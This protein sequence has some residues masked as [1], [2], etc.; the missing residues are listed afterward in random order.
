MENFNKYLTTS[1]LEEK[2]GFYI[3]TAGFSR[4]E[5][6]QAYPDNRQHPTTHAF[7]WDNGRILNGYYLIF[8]S[9]GEGIF[10]TEAAKPFR[11]S[12]G[13]CFVLFPG[14]WHRY[15]PDLNT[16]WE[17]YWIGF[18]GFYADE[19]IRRFFDKKKPVLYTGL[20]EDMLRL[21]QSVLM[22]IKDAKP[23]YHQEIAGITHQMLGLLNAMSNLDQTN[24]SPAEQLV[25]TAKFLLRESLRE[26]DRLENIIKDL[27]VSYSKFRKD[28]KRITGQSPNQ[29]QL[30]L[31]LEKV[32][33]LLSI[34]RLSVSEIAY[35]TGFDSVSH[36]SKT[37]TKKY[38]LSPRAYRL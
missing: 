27:P 11:I 31:R 29:Y 19:L 26:P 21:Y 10:E 20:N 36:L 4:I 7:D 24:A 35:Q 12:E 3:T 15:K 18:R 9:K 38:S 1:E 30:N 16:G 25:L 37:F 23:G 8:I 13:S 6:N 22:K 14:T 5:S 32:K 34:T 33:E 28:F 17:E 2:W